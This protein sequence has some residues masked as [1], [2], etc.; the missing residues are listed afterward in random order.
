M[1]AAP[2]TDWDRIQ[3]WALANLEALF[4][5][6]TGRPLRGG[7]A[8]CPVHGGDNPQAFSAANGK[9]W[10]CFTGDC[11][12]GDAVDLWR[13]LRHPNLPKKEGRLAALRELAP[14]ARVFLE[15]RATGRQRAPGGPR[16]PKPASPVRAK[17]APAT[18]PPARPPEPT[19]EEV[20]FAAL[21]PLRELGMI[22]ASRAHVHGFI[23]DTLTLGPRG[24]AYLEGRG[25]DPDA[26]H[27][28]GFRSFEDAAAWR[29]LEDA[30]AEEFTRD[31][32]M[33][34][35]VA[36]ANLQAKQRE[37]DRQPGVPWYDLEG[38]RSLFDVVGASLVIP[39]D[40]MAGAPWSFRLR[41]F[42]PRRWIRNGKEEEIRY[43]SL[44]N[45]DGENAT[46]FPFNAGALAGAAGQELHLV[47]GDLNAYTLHT[48]GVRAVG[49]PGASTTMRPA[50]LEA[51]RT[52]ARVVAWYDDDKAGRKGRKTLAETLAEM[53][54]KPWLEARG[55]KV[56][57]PPE[58]DA[59][60]LHRR[61]TLAPL[62][63]AA[64]WRA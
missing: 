12:S 41:A 31:E 62:M 6:L 4:T 11:G 26:A 29:M 55:R 48:Y 1:A 53:L 47:E 30:L 7:R 40:T 15:D 54:G 52:A 9:G 23:R 13:L 63:E 32:R 42:V 35:G 28:F 36:P 20:A 56:E 22:P 57:L 2:E 49:I 14:R 25:L 19:P 45:Y 33:A 37:E 17:P 64:A 51:I 3:A 58:I 39:Y 27:A 18:T 16:T 24:R 59:N 60:D 44:T 34:A 43:R 5:E 10:H 61:G 8:A 46:V 50:W 21:A 38:G